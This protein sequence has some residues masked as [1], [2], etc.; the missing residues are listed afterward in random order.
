MTVLWLSPSRRNIKCKA[1]FKGQQI[2]FVVLLNKDM[3]SP[4]NM[5]VY[6][7]SGK[8]LG[9]FMCLMETLNPTVSSII[10]TRSSTNFKLIRDHMDSVVIIMW[11]KEKI[12]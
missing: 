7:S 1:S 11:R 3:F 12:H 10:P 4:Y 6:M 9:I 2:A 8:H 5:K